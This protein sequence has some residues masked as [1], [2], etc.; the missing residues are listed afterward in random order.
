[1]RR[2][3]SNTSDQCKSGKL[4]CNSIAEPSLPNQ[5]LGKGLIPYLLLQLTTMLLVVSLSSLAKAERTST[6]GLELPTDTTYSYIASTGNTSYH[7]DLGAQGLLLLP[8]FE[9]DPQRGNLQLFQLNKHEPNP[10]PIRNFASTLNSRNLESEPR[11]IFTSD[12]NNHNKLLPVTL[13]NSKEITQIVNSEASYNHVEESDVQELIRYVHEPIIKSNKTNSSTTD[14]NRLGISCHSKPVVVIGK[15]NNYDQYPSFSDFTRV[16]TQQPKIVIVGTRDG[17]LH[18]F[19]LKT[20]KEHWSYIPPNILQILAH[21]SPLSQRRRNL[22]N[23]DTRIN[24]AD[25]FIDNMWRT[26]ITFKQQTSG[27]ISAID[28]TN[29]ILPEIIAEQDLGENFANSDA[30]PTF[31]SLTRQAQDSNRS[32]LDTYVTIA[33]S[34]TVSKKTSELALLKLGENS[35]IRVPIGHTDSEK[36]SFTDTIWLNTDIDESQDRGYIAS[37]DGKIYRVE[38]HENLADSRVVQLFSSPL[39]IYS[40]PIAILAKNPNYD[41]TKIGSNQKKYAVLLSFASARSPVIT[42][43]KINPAIY[44]LYDP[45]DFIIDNFTGSNKELTK[46]NFHRHSHNKIKITKTADSQVVLEPGKQGYFLTLEKQLYTNHGFIRPLGDP[47]ASPINVRGL[48][49]YPLWHQSTNENGTGTYLTTIQYQTGSSPIIDSSELVGRQVRS[50]YVTAIKDFNK[51]GTFNEK[52]LEQGYAMGII[53]PVI[54]ARISK[55]IRYHSSRGRLHGNGKIDLEDIKIDESTGDVLPTA[56][57]VSPRQATS[58][59]HISL[60]QKS[61]IMGLS[62]VLKMKYPPSPESVP[63]ELLSFFE[64]QKLNIFRFSPKI[65]NVKKVAKKQQKIGKQIN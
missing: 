25:I 18:A 4:G 28:I 9:L 57:Y 47:V 24:L 60:F 43:D 10:I 31:L 12:I 33:S 65:V 49:I 50:R 7:E 5:L 32:A 14:N 64:F 39:P 61:I 42:N 58:S 45:F 35:V 19:D 8:Y 56:I 54:D 6:C 51:D 62:A 11:R 26:V 30:M 15:N 59:P 48:I 37:S 27:H 20:G 55:T 40:T 63:D 44:G 23:L 29:R 52:D 21:I 3:T 1:M 13:E 41:P 2:R 17:L 34:S 16:M 22:P 38:L 36:I 46:R 53:E